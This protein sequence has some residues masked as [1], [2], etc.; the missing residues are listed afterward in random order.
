MT[1]NE[2]KEVFLGL[3][4]LE[5]EDY[6]I[7]WLEFSKYFESNPE[8]GKAALGIMLHFSSTFQK[9]AYELQQ[10]FDNSPVADC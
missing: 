7:V 5:K 10:I 4:K 1:A 8:E 6:N 9:S 3:S 2:I